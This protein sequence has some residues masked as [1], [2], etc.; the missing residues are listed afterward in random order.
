MNISTRCWSQADL[1]IIQNLLLETWLDA[2]GPFIPRADL[3]GY[4]QEHYA[5]PKL[6]AMFADPD[7]NGYVAEIDGAVG[8]YAKVYYDRAQQKVYLH[9]LYVLPRRQKLGLG[10]RLLACA[11]A[12]ARE[13]GCDRIWIGVMVRNERAVAWYRKLGYKVTE[14]APFVMGATSVEHYIGYLWV[15]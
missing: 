7:V 1:P 5:Q 4:L 13:L 12:R 8:G 3:T 9:Q 11:E 10:R 2:Y 6:Q 15:P 14:Q